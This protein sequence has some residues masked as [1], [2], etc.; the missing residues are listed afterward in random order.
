MR[1]KRWRATLPFSGVVGFKL[2]QFGAIAVNCRLAIGEKGFPNDAVGVGEIVGAMRMRHLGA[3]SII[4]PDDGGDDPPP[5][6]DARMEEMREAAATAPTGW[7]ACV[8]S[9]P[10]HPTSE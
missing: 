2:R 4:D 5:R 1:R 6:N 9:R 10:R 8:R 3:F 7:A